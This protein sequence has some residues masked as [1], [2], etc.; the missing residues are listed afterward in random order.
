MASVQGERDDGLR[1][2]EGA[3]QQGAL[4]EAR[5]LCQAALQRSPDDLRALCLMAA[6]A[7]DAKRIEEGAQWAKR[8]IATSPGAAA[9]HYAL[10]RVWESAGRYA[11]GEASYRNAVR[12]DPRHAKAHNNLGACLHMQG[13]IDEAI[14][15]YRKALEI[16]PA[17]PQAN[18]NYAAFVRDPEAQ[19]VAIAGYRRRIEQNPDDAA[20]L[21]NLANLL[22]EIGRH[23]DALACLEKATALDPQYAEAHL[24]K[25]FLLLLRGDYARGWKEYEWRWRVDA[26]NASVRRF[27]QP[28][29]DGRTGGGETVLIHGESGFGDMLQFVR[30][31]PLVA[32]R[33]GTVLLECQ[34]QLRPLLEGFEGVHRV[35]AR[36]EALP[37]FTAHVPLIMLPGIF[38][39]TLDD[40]A[41]RGPYVRAD[42]QRVAA[43]RSLVEP[44]PGLK[45]GLVWAGNPANWGDRKRSL[46]LDMLAPLARVPGATFYSLQVGPAAAEAASPPPGLRLV[47]HTGR[48][49]DFSD[50][51]ALISLLDAVLTIDT[52]VCHLGGAMG[53]P[54]WVLLGFAA[55]WRFHLERSDNP[56][57][58]TMRLFRQPRDG[59]WAGAVDKVVDELM[60]LRQ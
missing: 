2:A 59:D 10:G 44:G 24:S 37:P 3:Y 1:R 51:A 7:T 42:A 53:A 58:P 27:S 29:W 16:D 21:A 55:D 33:C 39:A 40:V 34:P 8:A 30:Y 22:V 49:R 15:C 43:W 60:R 6:I 13:R 18:Q 38:G 32:A 41:W 48:I 47:D 54:T 23:E 12:L 31:A 17:Q 50:T 19:Q 11:D 26:F 5:G 20:A 14:T 36:G 4:N 45:V 25:A 56:W 57:Y 35:V 46:S 9:A 28:V 52:S